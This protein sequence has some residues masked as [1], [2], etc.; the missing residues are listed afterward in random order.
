MRVWRSYFPNAILYG[1]DAFPDRLKLAEEDRLPN[2]YYCRADVK[3][4][5]SMFDAFNCTRSKFDILIDDSTHLF[6]DQ[7]DFVA[8]ATQFMKPGGLIVVEDVFRGWDE[9]KYRDALESYFPYFSSGTFIDC[10]HSNSYSAGS[11]EPYF[12]NDKLLVLVRNSVPIPVRRSDSKANRKLLDEALNSD[13]FRKRA[14]G[15][16]GTDSN[17]RSSLSELGIITRECGVLGY[18]LA[19]RDV[20]S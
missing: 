12:N 2:V 4:R 14:R 20:R 11:V 17:P 10:K 9:A 5:N 6:A 13:S 15:T 3:D 18:F 1:F 16:P 8:V 7:I 19:A